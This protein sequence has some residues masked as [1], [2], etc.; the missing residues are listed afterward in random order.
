MIDY[1]MHII[2]NHNNYTNHYYDYYESF[3][4]I[5]HQPLT[6][7]VFEATGAGPP[8]EAAHAEAPPGCRGSPCSAGCP[9]P[10]MAPGLVAGAR[11]GRGRNERNGGW[12]VPQGTVKRYIYIYISYIYIYIS[13]ISHILSYIYIIY[14]TWY[15]DIFVYDHVKMWKHSYSC[16]CLYLCIYIYIY[17][18]IFVCMYLLYK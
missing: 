5:S 14:I 18:H 7:M 2:M 17:L 9:P 10:E 1:C 11:D 3:W 8:V 4:I 13:Y 15:I 6:T 16:F 12:L